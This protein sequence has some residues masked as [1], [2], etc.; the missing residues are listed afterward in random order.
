MDR[1]HFTERRYWLEQESELW[2]THSHLRARRERYLELGDLAL[3]EAIE[4]A[5]VGVGRSIE[6]CA[7]A[8]QALRA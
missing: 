2:S 7:M 4:S 8:Q 1:D 5:L 6:L 3:A